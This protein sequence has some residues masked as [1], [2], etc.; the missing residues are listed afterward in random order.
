MSQQTS[1]FLEGKYGWNFGESGWN[2]GMDENL[3]KF[4]YML[5]NNVDSVTDSLPPAVDGEA[6]YLTTDNRIYFAIGTTYYSTPIPKWFV[7][8]EKTTGNCLQFNGTSLLAIDSPSNLASRLDSLETNESNLGTAAFEDVE[9]F[10]TQAELDVVEAQS[11]AYTDTLRSDLTNSV[12]ESLGAGLVGWKRSVL[13]ETVTLASQGLNATPVSIWE[14]AHL[15]TGYGVGLP[16][17]WDWQPAFQAACDAHF[18]VIVPETTNDAVYLVG[19][20]VKFNTNQTIRGSGKGGLSGND[21]IVATGAFA[22]FESKTKGVSACFNVVIEGLV[23]NQTDT[24]GRP[25]GSCGIDFTDVSMSVIRNCS[26]RYHEKNIKFGGTVAGYYNSAY[27]CEVSSADVGYYFGTAA[28]SIRVIGGR[29]HVCKK[30]IH[31]IGSNDCFVTS[32]LESCETGADLDTGTSGWY[33]F[34][35]Y[36]GNGRNIATD[37]ILTTVSGGVVMR[38]GTSGNHVFGHCSGGTDR[39]ID[40]GHNTVHS[41]STGY[42]GVERVA[43]ENAFYNP[44][45]EYD[46]DAN[47]VADGLA[48]TAGTGTTTSIDTEQFI[49][50]SRSQ[51]VTVAA[52]GGSRRDL[53]CDSFS[54][55]PGVEYVFACRVKT[56]LANGWNLRIGTSAGTSNYAN[57]QI[58][59][60]GDF[61]I[62]TIRFVATS[63]VAVAYFYMNSSTA[64]GN[65]AE[66]AKLWVDSVFFGKGARA[67]EFGE[68][69]R[70]LKRTVVNDPVSLAAGAQTAPVSLTVAGVALGDIVKASFSLSLQGLDLIAYASAANT[71]DF[72]FRNGTD[73]VVDLAS[74]TLLIV[75]DKV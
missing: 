59:M 53:I 70:K 19:A 31:A 37:A 18:T 66:D 22:A 75:V 74:G 68:H 13:A 15:A 24:T 8:K 6:H 43:N 52:A 29:V 36:E 71:V 1:P 62:M 57:T 3:L 65:L 47:G 17:T 33:L 26:F 10:A 73:S 45:M 39:I 9:F 42:S 2:T 60:V 64:A 44:S 51:L 67:P 27:D 35:R 25:V 14:F 46:S 30:G 34:S 28:N 40:L 20:P 16:S 54:T 63:T 48:L 7:I 5:D 21:R 23:I 55:T 4:S 72:V 38:A 49:T 32:A 56:N 41:R 12:D 69:S 11:S 50:G 58:G 61:T